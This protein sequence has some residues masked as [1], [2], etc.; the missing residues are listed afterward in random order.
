VIVI[1]PSMGF[2]TGHHATT[3]L[4]LELLQEIDVRRRRVIDVGTG[5]GVLAIAA[6]LLGASSVL[7]ADHD[8][9]ALLNARENVALNGAT[10]VEVRDADVRT[11]EAPPADV[12]LANLTAAVL[13]RT[14]ATLR[15]LVAAGGVAIVSG[16]GADELA[17]VQEGFGGRVTRTVHEGDWVAARLA[18]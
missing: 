2:G 5:S 13:Q 4:C 17:G 6:A 12:V 7:A 16:F 9:D 15:G 3:R 10:T 11:L 1:E 8:P 14:A 18:F